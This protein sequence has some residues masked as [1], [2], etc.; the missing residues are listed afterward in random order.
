MVQRTDKTMVGDPWIAGSDAQKS[1]LGHGDDPVTSRV[2]MISGQSIR[3]D[4][5]KGQSL[6]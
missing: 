3:P 4:K 5:H 1:A 2:S 6:L